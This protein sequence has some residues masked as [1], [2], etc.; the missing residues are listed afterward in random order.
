MNTRVFLIV[1]DSFGIGSLPDAA[2]YGDE[3]SHTLRSISASEKFRADMLQ[4]LGLF[5]IQGTEQKDGSFQKAAAPLAA[6]GRMAERS[7]GKDTTAG[8]WEIT[9][10]ITQQPFPTYPNGFPEEIITLFEQ[11]TGCSVLCNKVYS[12]T[13]VIRDYGK[14]QIDKKALIVYTSADSV[15]QVAAHES[16]FPPQT[17]YRFCETARELLTGK[18]GVGRVIARPFTGTAPNFIRTE[19]RRDFSL[20]PTGK[21]LL[22][23]LTEEGFD[24]LSVGKISDIFAGRGISEKYKTKNN[25]EGMAVTENLLQKDFHGLCFVNL[26]DFDMLYGHRNDVDGYAQAIAAFDDWLKTFLPQLQE[27]DWLILTADHGC[28]PGTASTDHSREYV[29]LLVYGKQ[30]QPKDL[31]TR[32]TFSDIAATIAELFHLR[33]YAGSG[34]SFLREI[35]KEKES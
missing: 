6:Y 30:A 11:K 2:R 24:V 31:K 4:N 14:E 34:K 16:V 22:D 26:V 32:N 17:L 29:P 27:N 9:G 19:N 33:R 28:D 25:A 18:H 20:E 23:N 7:A 12:G 13:E 8:H 1:L 35:Q 10:L 3:N 21:T 5:H 15:F